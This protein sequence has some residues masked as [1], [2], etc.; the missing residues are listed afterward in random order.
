MLAS[1]EGEMRGVRRTRE[2]GK[3]KGKVLEE[4]VSTKA[5]EEDLGTAGKSKR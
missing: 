1:S 2:A 4:R 5:K 3:A